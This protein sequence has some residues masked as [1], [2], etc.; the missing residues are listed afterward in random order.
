[1]IRFS[2]L[3]LAVWSLLLLAGRFDLPLQA[4]PVKP[5]LPLAR[6]V[7]Y[8]PN[9]ASCTPQ[10]ISGAYRNHLKPWED[11]PEPVLARL[12]LLQAEMTRTSLSRCIE[13][14]LLT[15][16][17]ARQVETSIGLV[18]PPQTSNAQ[19]GVRP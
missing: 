18:S 5:E 15:T 1:M 12:R 2:G 17:Q 10:A 16:D 8:E 4:E 13:Q 7:V 3:L 9:R 6:K 14:G 11:Q 19:S